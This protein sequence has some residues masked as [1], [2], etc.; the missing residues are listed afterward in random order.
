MYSCIIMLLLYQINGI[1]DDHLHK[2]M[3]DIDDDRDNN[4]D[5]AK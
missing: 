3:L 2:M 4:D 1:E 5:D